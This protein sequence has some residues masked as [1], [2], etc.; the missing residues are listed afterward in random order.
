[1]G[2]NKWAAIGCLFGVAAY[3]SCCAIGRRKPDFRA[4]IESPVA[5]A[6]IVAGFHLAYCVFFEPGHLAHIVDGDGN[7]VRDHAL[8]VEIGELHSIHIFVAGIVTVY[9]GCASLYKACKDAIQS[10]P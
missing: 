6:L 4:L 1:M 5:G 7:K 10:S 9:L 3:L 8:M 2:T